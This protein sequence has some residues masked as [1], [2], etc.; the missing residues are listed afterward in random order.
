MFEKVVAAQEENGPTGPPKVPTSWEAIGETEWR[1]LSETKT[2]AARVLRNTTGGKYTLKTRGQQTY[3][4]PLIEVE[5]INFEPS[6]DDNAT[7]FSQ[8]KWGGKA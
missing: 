7:P 4:I 2:G 5:A 8:S 6:Y 1:Q 3:V